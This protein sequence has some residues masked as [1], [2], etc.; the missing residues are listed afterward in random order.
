MFL[1]IKN[2]FQSLNFGASSLFT[3]DLGLSV[4]AMSSEG[5]TTSG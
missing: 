5:T 3:L 1:Q 2:S 4:E